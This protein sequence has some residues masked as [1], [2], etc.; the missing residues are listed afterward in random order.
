MTQGH[1]VRVPLGRHVG[2]ERRRHSLPCVS[3]TSP[4]HP[5]GRSQTGRN[6]R[7]VIRHDLTTAQRLRVPRVHV[8]A[9][10]VPNDRRHLFVVTA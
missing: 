3:S 8:P 4:I 10:V 5:F 9:P 2:G 7:L 6:S 1:S